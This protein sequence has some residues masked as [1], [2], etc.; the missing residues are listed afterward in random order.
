MSFDGIEDE[1]VGLSV[2]KALVEGKEPCGCIARLAVVFEVLVFDTAAIV[3]RCG[4]VRDFACFGTIA[5]LVVVAHDVPLYLFTLSHALTVEFSDIVVLD[6]V[7]E[8]AVAGLSVAQFAVTVATAVAQGG[9]LTAFEFLP[10]GYL[11]AHPIIIVVVN[12]LN[13]THLPLVVPVHGLNRIRSVFRIVDDVGVAAGGC[14]V[15][16]VFR[17][18]LSAIAIPGASAEEFKLNTAVCRNPSFGNG[19]ARDGPAVDTRVAKGLIDYS[20]IPATHV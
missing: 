19:F 20:R 14:K 17:G 6:G 11:G 1:G 13:D 7:G 8:I 2:F 10:I 5:H 4:W 9:E 18:F 16:P 12:I 15:L 3:S